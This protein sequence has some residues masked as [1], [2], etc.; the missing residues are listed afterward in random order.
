MCDEPLL[1][2]EIHP[3]GTEFVFLSIGACRVDRYL[4]RP[5]EVEKQTWP[6]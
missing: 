4:L 6:P 1:S 2:V 3:L 5:R